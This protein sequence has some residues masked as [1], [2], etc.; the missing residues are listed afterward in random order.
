MNPLEAV[1]GV[2]N[3]SQPLP[4]LLT[5][6]QPG[7]AHLKALGEAGVKVI[8]DIRDPMEPRPFDE[9]AAAKAAGLEYEQVTVRQGAL[10]DAVMERV[11]TVLRKH[12]GHPTFFHCASGNRCGGPL[13]AYLMLDKKQ[14]EE[15]AVEAAMRAGLRGADVLEWGVEYAQRKAGG[16]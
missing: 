10:D 3:A 7:L 6:G 5:G 12:A 8:F 4:H 11:L 1:S 2:A 14:S 9:A 13:I 15:E 16:A